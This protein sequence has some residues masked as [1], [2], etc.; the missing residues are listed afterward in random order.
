[1]Y[2]LRLLNGSTARILNPSF[3]DG[4]P[5]WL[6]GTDAGLLPAPVEVTSV[7]LAPG[8]RVEILVDLRASAGQT[9]DFV[10]AAFTIAGGAPPTAPPQGAALPMMRFLVDL[11]LAGDPGGIPHGFGPIAPPPI[12]VG[13]VRQFQLTQQAGQHFINGRVY[14]LARVDFTVPLGQP[15]IWR[16]VNA[17]NFPHPMHVHG[18]HFRVLS[19]SGAPLPTDA[20]WKDTVLVR[21]GETVDVA[22]RFDTPGLFVVH[23]H[24]LEHEDM[25]M[26]LNFVVEPPLFRDGFE[27][28]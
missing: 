13:P 25:G 26:M 21:V 11:P 2:R 19:R 9:L 6:V 5:F 16:F 4:R 27:A 18:A 12:T 23:C 14:D 15:E 10:S 1:V 22:L 3:Q 28:G 24:N 20:G 7:L 17:A 8:E